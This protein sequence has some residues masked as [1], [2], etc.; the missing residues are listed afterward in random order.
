MPA[1]ENCKE[2]QIRDGDYELFDFNAEVE[3]GP[4]AL[5]ARLKAADKA[6]KTGQMRKAK[7]EAERQAEVTM[8]TKQSEDDLITYR[9]F[10]Q[11]LRSLKD[12][13]YK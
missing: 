8:A 3:S 11:G 13:L 6:A 1:K 7:V 12:T 4:A 9:E 10:F 5:E 2:T